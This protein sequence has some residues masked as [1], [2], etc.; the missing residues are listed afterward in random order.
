MSDLHPHHLSTR[1]KGRVGTSHSHEVLFVDH[2][3]E[4]L[5]R[6]QK[7]VFGNPD[8]T[9]KDLTYEQLKDLP[10]LDAVI[11]ETLRIRAPLQ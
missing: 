2:R 6:E 7:E 10:L 11:R 8:G 9:F 1:T 3:S 5:Y 4:D